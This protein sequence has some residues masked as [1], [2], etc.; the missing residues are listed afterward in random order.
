MTRVRNRARKLPDTVD[1]HC[2]RSLISMGYSRGEGMKALLGPTTDTQLD[3]LVRDLRTTY[4][5]VTEWPY[6]MPDSPVVA[7]EAQD[8]RTTYRGV[9]VW[10]HEMTDNPM[11]ATEADELPDGASSEIG[12]SYG[13]EVRCRSPSVASD[14]EWDVIP[15]YP[16]LARLPQGVCPPYSASLSLEPDWTVV[17]GA[18]Q[19]AHAPGVEFP[20]DSSSVLDDCESVVSHCGPSVAPRSFADAARS[21]TREKQPK[22]AAITSMPPLFARPK[23]RGT[24]A[25]RSKAQQSCDRPPRWKDTNFVYM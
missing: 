19:L 3:E 11:V 9:T 2:L 24:V 18:E 10:P 7:K 14:E 23:S 17:S 20:D 15:E 8:L 25:A 21:N 16:E 6:E 13:G 4:G 12:A 5:G 22:T 1:A